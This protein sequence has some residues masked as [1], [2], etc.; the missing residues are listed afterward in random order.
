MEN[1]CP[2]NKICPE[3]KINLQKKQFPFQN[4][5]TFLSGELSFQPE[6]IPFLQN[7]K[8]VLKGKSLS[9]TRKS[10]SCPRKTLS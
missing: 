4:E 5:K 9:N 2:V 7:K 3:A 6:T 10:F 1:P 8:H